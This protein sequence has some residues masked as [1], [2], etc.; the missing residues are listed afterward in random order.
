[1]IKVCPINTKLSLDMHPNSDIRC[2]NV[3]NTIYKYRLDAFRQF[4]FN[5]KIDKDEKITTKLIS[6]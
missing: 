5:L 3:H 6:R 4:S 1:M 2:T